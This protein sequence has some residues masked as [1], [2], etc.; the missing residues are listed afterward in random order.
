MQRARILLR[1][2]QL[3]PEAESMLK[4]KAVLPSAG[5][6]A[7]GLEQGTNAM[8]AKSEGRFVDNKPSAA[9]IAAVAPGT[10]FMPTKA[11]Y[12]LYSKITPSRSLRAEIDDYVPV[13][14]FKE[15]NLSSSAV[16]A[17][18]QLAAVV[19]RHELDE[20]R[21]V[22]FQ[23]QKARQKP[24]P[25]DFYHESPWV[26][27]QEGK[28]L[29]GLD[30]CVQNAMREARIKSGELVRIRQLLGAKALQTGE[31]RF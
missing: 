14:S 22:Y 7:E 9:A 27:Q 31:Y 19:R 1:L 23:Q 30:P 8:I 11:R 10:V 12:P 28:S 3:S 13:L 25:K 21:V 24:R 17:Q 15:I 29:V 16:E 5:R 4:I 6:R 2:G 20:I 18:K 26:L